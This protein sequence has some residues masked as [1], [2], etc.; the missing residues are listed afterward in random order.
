MYSCRAWPWDG[1]CNPD[2]LQYVPGMCERLLLS[3]LQK[4]LAVSTNT[5]LV[6]RS[7]NT[8]IMPPRPFMISSTPPLL[9]GGW[10]PD[11]L[12]PGIVGMRG[13]WSYDYGHT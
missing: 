5:L 10:K 2:L 3:H 9:P 13:L 1:K 12:R 6:L 4:S 11:V 7:Q 8:T